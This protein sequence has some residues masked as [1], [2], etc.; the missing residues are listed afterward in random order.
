[1]TTIVTRANKGSPL[2]NDELD[3]NFTNLSNDCITLFSNAQSLQDTRAFLG[4]NISTVSA[5][6]GNT[7]TNITTLFAN[8]ATQAVAINSLDAN[9]GTATT[10]ITTLTS[11]AAAQS[12]AINSRSSI[13]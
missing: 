2:S 9:L 6:L 4:P 3:T 7:T 12:V 13:C 10:N 11:N 1:M 8:A 5:N